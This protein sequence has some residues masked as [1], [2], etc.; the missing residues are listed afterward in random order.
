MLF[1]KCIRF[2]L[3]FSLALLSSRFGL[4]QTYT[5]LYSFTGGTDGAFP[6]AGVI[7]DSSGNLYGTTTGQGAGGNWGSV[8]KLSPK[9]KFTLL[10]NFGA[11]GSSGSL[12][13]TPLLR[14][15]A[16]NLFATTSTHGGDNFGTVYTIT[17][18]KQFTVRYNFAAAWN[19]GDTEPL[20]ALT[21]DADGNLY[22]AGGGGGICAHG[23][24]CGVVFKLDPSGNQTVINSFVDGT[25]GC[26]PNGGLLRD[27]AGNLYGTAMGCGKGGNGVVFKLDSAG[28]E[29]VLYTFKGIKAG[30]GS[31]PEAGLVQDAA[32]NFYG[33][34][35]MGGNRVGCS[36]FPPKDCGVIFKLD[37]NGIE[38]VLYRFTG[39]ADGG[40]P[41]GP[42][43]IDAAGN[44]YGTARMSNPGQGV[45]FKLDP[46]GHETVLYT[47]GGGTD[48]AGP[49]GGVA[50]DPAGNLYGTTFG[51]GD[52]NA[53]TTGG[54]SGCGVVFQITQ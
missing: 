16:G 41:S 5:V 40:R 25:K 3:V 15:S 51:G 12:P 39:G 33:A 8:F 19:A 44:L 30:D 32:G 48:G 6:V 2:F 23:T 46:S 43:V 42:L 9:G 10:H 29:T 36:N 18:N 38:S 47:F 14:D 1:K 31:K 17:K 35:P 22:G 13:E 26:F 37:P 27:A 28:N 7:R 49:L 50:I 24:R 52:P 54:G 4:A 20:G 21:L 11:D 34:T 53:C 45:I